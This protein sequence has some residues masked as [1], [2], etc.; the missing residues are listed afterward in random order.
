VYAYVHNQV[1]S[2][3]G[4]LDELLAGSGVDPA[5]RVTILTD[6]AGEFEKAAK[7]C[8]QPICQILDAGRTKA[9]RRPLGRRS[10]IH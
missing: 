10:S 3:A 6:D 1:A 4:R 8:A 9:K 2:A 7:G 5:A